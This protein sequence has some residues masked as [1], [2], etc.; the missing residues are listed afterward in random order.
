MLEAVVWERVRPLRQRR[1]WDEVAEE[2]V[3]GLDKTWPAGLCSR[4]EA[5]TVGFS[6][7]PSAL[8]QRFRELS[9]KNPKMADKRAGAIKLLKKAGQVAT[10]PDGM[11]LWEFFKPSSNVLVNKG[12]LAGKEHS[13]ETQQA[14]K[15]KARVAGEGSR[16]SRALISRRP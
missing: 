2:F 13:L 9:R 4:E 15:K 11:T 6:L 7:T 3:A 12:A 8:G 5:S 10:P 14:A 1:A 16:M